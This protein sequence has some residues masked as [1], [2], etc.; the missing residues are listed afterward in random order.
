M[1]NSIKIHELY[2]YPVSRGQAKE[3]IQKFDHNTEVFLDFMD[4]NEMG[5]SF[6]DEIFRVYKRQ[7]P[8]IKISVENASDDVKRMIH[9]VTG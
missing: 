3:L 9:H 7:H 1:Y 2:H 4:V 8:E 5:P 6:A